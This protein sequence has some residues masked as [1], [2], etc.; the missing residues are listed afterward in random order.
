MNAPKKQRSKRVAVCLEMEWGHKRH[1]EAYAGVHKYA[2]EA[3]WDCVT[4]PSAARVLN[5]ESSFAPFDGILGRITEPLARAATEIKIPAVNIWINSPAK[6]IA[7]VLADLE[8]SGKMAAQ[9]LLGRGFRRFGYMGFL[10][11]KDARYQI[12]GFR[13]ILKPLGFRFTNYRFPRTDLGGEGLGWEKFL[14]GLEQWVEAWEPPIGV[15]VGNDLYCRHLIETCR[16]KGLKVPQD[17]AIVG[18]SNEPAICSSPYPTL[19]SIDLDFELI[20][21]RAA[22]KLDEMM[23]SKKALASVEYSPPKGLI[24]RQS[25]DSLA[26]DDPLV[27]KALRFISENGH[28]RILVDDVVFS[29]GTN[30]RTLERKFRASMG[31]SIAEEI[32][33]LRIERSKRLM[34]ETDASL[35]SLAVDLGFRNADHFCKVFSRIEKITP[36]Q[37]RKREKREE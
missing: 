16:A 6:N 33:R 35:K 12:R 24:P 26:A 15:L 32:S 7:S 14:V 17:V 1:L 21:Y 30:R 22:E 29:S 34:L 11:E 4:T 8:A 23:N 28:E 10:R 19:T 3:G 5:P 27:A 37:Y 13:Q 18:T 9:H 20:G 31:C 36:S 2:D 25:T